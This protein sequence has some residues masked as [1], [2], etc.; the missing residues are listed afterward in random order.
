[1]PRPT[2][3]L[4]DFFGTLVAYADSRTALDHRETY[5]R[6]LDFGARVDYDG[7]LAGWSATWAEFDLLSDVDDHE[8]SVTDV[9][10]AYLR[11]ALGREPTTEET[12]SFLAAY[13]TEWNTG[14]RY[15]DGLA[16]LLA[17]LG[18]DH[19]LAV[20]SNTHDLRLVPDHLDALG[21]RSLMT[22]VVL[23]VEVGWR[24]P[25]PAIYESTLSELGIRPD[26]AVFVGDS[27][28]AD[29]EGPERAGIRSFLIDPD[30]RTPVPADRRLDSIFDLPAA[31]L[32]LGS[33]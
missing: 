5:D 11:S 4:L 14:V 22:A 7:F 30:R 13:I 8:F 28:R 24:K 31:L 3:I 27:Y 23:S 33:A 21:V 2:H 6:L 26:E 9:G 16:E 20:V 10:T 12:R 18:R 32:H 25:H 15:L 1:M 19:R 17:V 29:F